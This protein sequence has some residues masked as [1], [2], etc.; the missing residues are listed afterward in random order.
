MNNENIA[1]TYRNIE[2]TY[3]NIQ[4]ASKYRTYIT[5]YCT[6]ISKYPTHISKYRTYINKYCTPISKYPTHISK[7]CTYITK[8]CTPIS[9][10]PTHIS[11]YRTYITKF[12]TPISK[13][14]T[15]ISK[16]R[17]YITKYCTPISTLSNIA[18]FYTPY[19][20]ECWIRLF[21]Q[22]DLK[23]TWK[24]IYN[25]KLPPFL[26]VGPLSKPYNWIGVCHDWF[27][28]NGLARA[29]R[30]PKQAW[31][32]KWKILVYRGIQTHTVRSRSRR[33]TS[34][35]TWSDIHIRLMVLATI[36]GTDNSLT[37]QICTATQRHSTNA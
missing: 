13:Y 16:Y 23:L 34:C 25:V 19:F 20:Y 18:T 3:Q 8:Y 11:K 37:R 28:L 7:Y 17:T 24:V 9:K 15:H 14:S 4:H 5:K 32:T 30:N 26:S 33:A 12:C 10:Y 35:A 1:H 6:S 36:P 31:N 2:H 27:H 21:P 22:T 29:A